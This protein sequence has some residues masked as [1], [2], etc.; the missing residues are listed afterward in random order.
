M[1]PDLL[2][3][4]GF[5][6]P[7]RDDRPR[8]GVSACL[9]GEPVRHDGG[10]RRHGLVHDQLAPL[11]RLT[12][13]CPE[14]GIGLPVPRPPI[15]VVDL[16]G[17]HRVRGVAHPERDVTEALRD[18]ARHLD[19][20]LSGFVFKSRSQ[21]VA[22]APRR[23]TIAR[24]CPGAWATAP[25]PRPSPGAIPG[26]RWPTTPISTTP[27]SPAPSCCG[28]S[29]ITTGAPAAPWT[30]C[31]NAAPRSANRCARAPDVFLTGWPGPR[32]DRP[33]S[34]LAR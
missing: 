16:N 19:A 17:E 26:C 30:R 27:C 3:Q 25:S 14:V 9:M 12:R 32:P 4:M 21:A 10:H 5:D 7:R 23:C 1:L 6:V 29:A 11:V 28:C 13:V 24:A 33:P 2:R 34:R 8:V 18:Q 20:P 31:A 22:W 15:Q